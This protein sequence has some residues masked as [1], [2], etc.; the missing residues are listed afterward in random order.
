M[1]LRKQNEWM[2]QE[3]VGAILKS[4]EVPFEVKINSATLISKKAYRTG[5]EQAAPIPRETVMQ[6]ASLLREVLLAAP[7]TTVLTQANVDPAKAAMLLE[8]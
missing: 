8:D 4:Q 5:I 1:N 3:N 2:S 7:V 6:A